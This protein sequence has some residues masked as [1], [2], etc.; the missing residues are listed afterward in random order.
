MLNS[1]EKRRLSWL[2]KEF[3]SPSAISDIVGID[4]L[5]SFVH[6]MLR[7]TADRLGRPLQAG[8]GG[9]SRYVVELWLQRQRLLP[10]RTAALQLGM[11]EESFGAILDN[12]VNRGSI[13]PLNEALPT[14]LVS[15]ETV[16]G[17][18]RHFSSLQGRTFS[19]QTEFSRRLHAAAKS[20]LGVKVEPVQCKVSA[21]LDDSPVDYA[22][23][24]CAISHEP[25]GL[26]YAEILDSGK[27]LR[28]SPDEVSWATIARAYKSLRPKLMGAAPPVEVLSKLKTQ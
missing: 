4:P 12:L 23:Y 1:T 2:L 22:F 19:T 8:D 5:D 28:L 11:T 24:L 13:L 9:I 10:R 14:T 17:L 20:E 16:R 7:E 18:R 25:V 6:P 3:I 27:P 15:E 21:A 26:R